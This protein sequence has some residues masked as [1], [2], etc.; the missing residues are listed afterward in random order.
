MSVG[1]GVVA[2][3]ADDSGAGVVSGCAAAAG[4]ADSG[5]TGT[6]AAGLVLFLCGGLPLSGRYSG[7]DCPQAA[8]NSV[9]D[10][11]AGSFGMVG[12]GREV[13]FKETAHKLLRVI[14]PAWVF[15]RVDMRVLLATI[16]R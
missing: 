3:A 10:S 14:H 16:E 9:I 12:T 2:G 8:S 1:A 15:F 6:T 7:P 11:S 5:A 4:A 13:Q